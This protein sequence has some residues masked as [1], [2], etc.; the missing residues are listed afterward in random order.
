[1]HLSPAELSA[2][3]LRR[4]AFDAALSD[5]RV[6][7]ALLVLSAPLGLPRLA[8]CPCCGYPT[9]E[10][11]AGFDICPLC[12]W[13][14]DGQDDDAADAVWGGPNSDYSLT[15]A[16]RNFIDYRAKYR[17]GDDRFE[18]AAATR[19]HRERIIA[20][21][22][23]LLPAV[24]A[25]QFVD[26]L[27]EIERL[28]DES[29]REQFG[30]STETEISAGELAN[31][32]RHRE[33]AAWSMIARRSLAPHDRWQ[34]SPILRA[35]RERVFAEFVRAVRACLDEL[36]RER[37]TTFPQPHVVGDCASWSISDERWV[38]VVQY[39]GK[40]QAAVVFHPARENA[41]TPY[42]AFGDARESDAAAVLIADHLTAADA[43]P[44]AS[45]RRHPTAG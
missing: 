28:H 42:F 10:R 22:D 13:E 23:A 44:A 24:H 36:A 41:E 12:S 31:R 30:P 43:A 38:E 1:M 39:Y 25:W 18:R 32:L 33:W 27:P 6:Q 35:E 20:A 16:R 34:G 29:M 5:L 4:L 11:R 21:Y 2:L 14:D 17:P 3:A 19:P 37:G 40:T 9:L 7:G 45:R 15:E 8:V 26:A